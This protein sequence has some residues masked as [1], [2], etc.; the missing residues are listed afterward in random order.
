MFA[1]PHD[2]RLSY[3]L[4]I[5]FPLPVFFSFVFTSSKGMHRYAACLRFYEIVPKE[6][7]EKVFREVYGPDAVRKKQF[8]SLFFL[9]TYNLLS[10]LFV[11][12][13]L[14]DDFKCECN[15]NFCIYLISLNFLFF[16]QQL[17]LPPS[18]AVFCPKIICV[19]SRMPFYR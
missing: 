19:V 2:L 10:C 3:S 14:N 17:V 15:N 1:F 12:N 7:I 16:L 13:F 11:L 5:R 4:T 9:F 6:E 8:F 18:N